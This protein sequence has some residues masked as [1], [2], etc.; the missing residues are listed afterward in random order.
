M[1]KSEINL[2]IAKI[3]ELA[4]ENFHVKHLHISAITEQITI[5][6]EP[7]ESRQVERKK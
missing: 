7:K 5:K 4:E 6:L 3:L 1:Q 2:E